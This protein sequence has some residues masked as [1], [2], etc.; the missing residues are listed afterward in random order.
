MK[1]L[2]Q[3]ALQASKLAL[4]FFAFNKALLGQRHLWAALGVAADPSLSALLTVR[5]KCAIQ[6][7]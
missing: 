1:L 5:I 2:S 7:H 3:V 4:G 6:T